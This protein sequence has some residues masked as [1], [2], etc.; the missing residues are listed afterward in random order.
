MAA[1]T[2]G[3]ELMGSVRSATATPPSLEQFSPGFG[4]RHWAIA[5]GSVRSVVDGR[6]EHPRTGRR[7]L[8]EV[9]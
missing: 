2:G 6:D 9:T 3:P 7:D 8:L 1:R 4:N 5:E